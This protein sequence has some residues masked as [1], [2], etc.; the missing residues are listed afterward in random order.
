MSRITPEQLDRLIELSGKTAKDYASE[1][2]QAAALEEF[3]T[4]YFEHA[5]D[6]LTFAKL[7]MRAFV[8]H[9]M[10]KEPA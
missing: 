7:G 6:I 3:M 1:L 5:D 8:V 2:Q 9:E 10:R 4:A